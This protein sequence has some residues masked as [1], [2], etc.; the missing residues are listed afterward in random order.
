MPVPAT[1]PVI[2]RVSLLGSVSATLPL[3]PKIALP[4]SVL[5]TVSSCKL[6]V[7]TSSMASG[8][9]F[10]SVIVPVPTALALM[11]VPA[12]RVAVSV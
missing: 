9:L 2:D 10:T 11:V 12:V 3:P 4:E 8:A 1:A 7:G 6:L 5:F